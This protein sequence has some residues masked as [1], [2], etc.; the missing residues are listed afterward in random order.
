MCRVGVRYPE[1]GRQTFSVQCRRT[2]GLRHHTLAVQPPGALSGLRGPSEAMH[3]AAPS[4]RPRA[5]SQSRDQQAFRGGRCSARLPRH[6]SP[7][8]SLLPALEWQQRTPRLK[9]ASRCPPLGKG[10]GVVAS[11]LRLQRGLSPGKRI[12]DERSVRFAR[13]RSGAEC[14]QW[15][16][17]D[18]HHRAHLRA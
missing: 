3:C 4:G 14:P 11:A 16:E 18:I 15:G 9:G 7:E 1:N 6:R 13:D 12:V 10:C 17:G 5:A 2:C 8:T